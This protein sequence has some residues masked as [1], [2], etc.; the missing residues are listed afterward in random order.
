MKLSEHKNFLKSKED[1]NLAKSF[2]NDVLWNIN[3]DFKEYVI[4]QY[5]NN[6]E[7]IDGNPIFSALYGNHKAIRIIQNPTTIQEPIFTS[8]INK[9]AIGQNNVIELVIMLQPNDYLINDTIYLIDIFLKNRSRIH[10]NQKIDSLNKKYQIKWD[11]LRSKKIIKKFNDLSIIDLNNID[12][13]QSLEISTPVLKDFV[14]IVAIENNYI[15]VPAMV[16][17]TPMSAALQKVGNSVRNLAG[18]VTVKGDYALAKT[19]SVE[20]YTRRVKKGYNN[21]ANFKRS[22]KSNLLKLNKQID[23][24]KRETREVRKK[25]N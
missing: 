9:T 8:W 17:K 7:I 18:V 13:I 24:L 5:R 15:N 16:I 19:P 20:G 12:S 23:H 6:E 21:T 3:S 25:E 4:N 11:L 14:Q 10:L 2:W 1:Y 22:I